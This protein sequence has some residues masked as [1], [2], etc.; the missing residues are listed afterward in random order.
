MLIGTSGDVYNFVYSVQALLLILHS[1]I[2]P[3]VFC[4]TRNDD[5][6]CVKHFGALHT[7]KKNRPTSMSVW[8]PI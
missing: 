7:H 3:Q 4:C 6:M 2:H 5:K 8:V 1:A